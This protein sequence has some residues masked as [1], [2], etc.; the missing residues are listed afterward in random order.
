[1]ADMYHVYGHPATGLAVGP[2]NQGYGAVIN[3]RGY[4]D[5]YGKQ[6][7]VAVPHL[8]QAAYAN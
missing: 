4:G 5:H 2:W 6:P 3:A 1:M 7:G 8:T